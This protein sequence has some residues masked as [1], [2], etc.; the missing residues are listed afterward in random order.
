MTA[1]ERRILHLALRDH[2]ELTTESHGEGP[3]RCVVVSRKGA[4]KKE[5]P[6]RAQR[7]PRISLIARGRRS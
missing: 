3:R 5:S 4:A 2:P 6:Q 1:R 7:T